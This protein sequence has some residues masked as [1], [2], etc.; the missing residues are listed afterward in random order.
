MPGIRDRN[1]RSGNIHEELGVL[2]L[3]PVALVAPVPMWEDVGLDAVAT[4]LRP[5]GGR[6]LIP[7]DTFAVQLKASSLR[8]IPYADQDAARWLINLGLP[9]FIGSVR[10]ADAAIDLYPTHGL[11]KVRPHPGLKEVHLNLE[12]QA[13][14]FGSPEVAQIYIGPPALSWSANDLSNRAF[15]DNA[16]LV[17][18]GHILAANRNMFGRAMGHFEPVLWITGKPPMQPG[19]FMLQGGGGRDVSETLASM[20]APIRALILELGTQNRL[21]LLPG[22]FEFVKTMRVLGVDPDQEDMLLKMALAGSPNDLRSE[23]LGRLLAQGMSPAR[24]WWQGK[25][26][27]PV[28]PSSTMGTEPQPE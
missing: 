9:F 2:L 6:R 19:T 28:S 16:Y 4:L 24:F 18:K 26:V 27:D 7:E 23:V 11:F 8:T 15:S 20:V 21:S 13:E 14:R 1:L 10:L 22:L 25:I 17:L 5:E 3:R 12:D